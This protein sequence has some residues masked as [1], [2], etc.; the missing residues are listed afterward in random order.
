MLGF[1]LGI[2]GIGIT[3]N[4]FKQRDFLKMNVRF[5]QKVVIVQKQPPLITKLSSLNAAF[6]FP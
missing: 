5:H 3:Q 2:S 4:P 6:L 1:V